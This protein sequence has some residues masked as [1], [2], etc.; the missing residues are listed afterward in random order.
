MKDRFVFLVVLLIIIISGLIYYQFQSL[1]PYVKP[2]YTD[3]ELIIQSNPPLC[4]KD[5]L[6]IR[7]KINELIEVNLGEQGECDAPG[8]ITGYSNKCGDITVT[9]TIDYVIKNTSSDPWK[10]SYT[11]S[12][13]P[14]NAHFSKS[15]LLLPGNR[16]FIFT[17]EGCSTPRGEG[18]CRYSFQ[19]KDHKPTFSWESCDK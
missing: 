19:F 2:F 9:K 14:M 10:S 7:I 13:T 1:V 11:V 3:P 17:D 4:D 18:L 8:S 6:T 15:G 16:Y 12:Q 5:G